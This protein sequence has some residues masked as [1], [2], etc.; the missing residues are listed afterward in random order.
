[1]NRFA[2]L[3]DRLSYEGGR[4]NKLRLMT[5]Y[6]RST[7]DPDR[8]YALAALT[9]ALTFQHAKPN[10]LRT[11]IAERTDPV[12]FA[13]SRDYVGD[14]SE[15]IALMWPTPPD[16]AQQG[17]AASL[18]HIVETLAT[19]GKSELPAQLARW[20]DAL[21]ETGRWALVK[22]ITGALRV[23]VSARLAKTAVAALGGKDVQEIELL[24]PGLSPPYLELFAWLEGCADKPL[25]EDPAPFRPPML[26]HAI[27]GGDFATLDPAGFVAE[28]KWD[29]V[30]IQAVAGTGAAGRVCRLYSRTGEDISN[31][32]PELLEVM[33]FDG[34][35]DGELLI[36]RDGRCKVSTCCS[37]GSTERWLRR[38]CWQSFL[39]IFAPT[40]C[41]STA[42]TICATGPSA[43]GVRG[44]KNFLRGSMTRA[45]TFRRSFRLRPGN[46]LSPCALIQPPPALAP[47]PRRSKG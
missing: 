18:A 41:W 14:T 10:L 36:L 37:S 27:E 35:I 8:G 24:W 32:F 34:A 16:I 46:R 15:T 28:W 31:G 43:S 47:M 4:N 21:D 7:G 39:R 11:L 42:L 38:N 45:S 13:L 2:D 23:G 9:G 20:L 1:M 44:S 22:L 12:L 25:M 33:R 3:L 19:L 26:S 5:E 29:G 40:I 6:F 30:R 17:R